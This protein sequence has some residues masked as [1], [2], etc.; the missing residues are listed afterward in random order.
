MAGDND[1]NFSTGYNTGT[2]SDP[3]SEAGAR[4]RKLQQ[5]LNEPTVPTGTADPSL[6]VD[7]EELAGS[8][9][10]GRVLTGAIIP[11]IFRAIEVLAD[12]L[13]GLR[14]T[15]ILAVALA[16]AT[17]LFA[18]TNDVSAILGTRIPYETAVLAGAVRLLAG[19]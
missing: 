4:S 16:V 1:G 10:I 14:A 19:C 18:A 17:A 6:R 5:A 3:I 11:E 7:V 9:L 8:S 15:F 13:L 12:T 2:V